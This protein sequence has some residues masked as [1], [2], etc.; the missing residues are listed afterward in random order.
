MYPPILVS[1][2]FAG[3]AYIE[4]LASVVSDAWFF[5]LRE[6]CLFGGV[7]SRLRAFC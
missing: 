6:R 5:L 7:G 3:E 4:R 1:L 2:S